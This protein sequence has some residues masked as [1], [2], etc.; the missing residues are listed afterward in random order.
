MLKSFNQVSKEC[1]KELNEYTNCVD[2]NK[3]DWQ[4]KCTQ[5]KLN[6][7]KCSER[8]VPNLQQLNEKCSALI[9]NFNNCVNSNPQDP[10]LH[11]ETALKKLYDCM[12]N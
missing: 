1:A 3:S 6:L 8:S 7:S 2:A 11:C 9:T 10:Q 5:Q 12:G 4:V